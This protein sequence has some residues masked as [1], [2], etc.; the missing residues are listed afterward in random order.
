MS[1]RHGFVWTALLLLAACGGGHPLAGGWHEHTGAGHGFQFEFDPKSN[2]LEV[3]TRPR[4][5]GTHDHV[6]GTYTL[7]GQNLAV[8]WT[9]GGKK[10]ALRGTLDGD[11]IVL[12]GE[13]FEKLQ[14]E[15][16]AAGH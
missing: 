6:A 10:V 2:Q 13:G 8:E 16:G 15:R 12:S 14:L 11:A 5:D 1:A 3:H 4:A 7:D 9:D